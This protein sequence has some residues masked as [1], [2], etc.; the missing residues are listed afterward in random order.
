MA[1]LFRIECHAIYFVIK[2]ISIG[3]IAFVI[4]KWMLLLYRAS[5][6]S[7]NRKPFRNAFYA[8]KDRFIEVP[9]EPRL[10]NYSNKV[11]TFRFENALKALP[12]VIIASKFFVL[13]LEFD[14]Y[15][16]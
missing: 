7:H 3:A 13:L 1:S 12:M 11:K 2:I 16:Q 5:V 14:A 10:V 9:N 15:S 4:S 6:E 8:E